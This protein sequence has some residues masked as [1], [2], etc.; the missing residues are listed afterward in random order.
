M[1][2]ITEIKYNLACGKDYREGYINV[3]NGSMFTSKVD[4]DADLNE[5]S[6]SREEAD[7]IL[8]SH[9]VMYLT[10]QNAITLF[11]RW[12][13]GL[14]KGGQLILEMQD[15]KKLAKTILESKEASEINN[16]VVQFY[17]AGATRGHVWTWCEETLT[18]LLKYSGFTNI[19]R[20]EGGL[21]NRLDRDF[22][23]IATK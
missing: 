5:F 19:E 16:Q 6:I 17:G 9:F 15:L 11:E 20:F 10:P 7:T 14:K 13:F 1:E 22:T 21:K 23:L 8:V 18:P 4:I 12:N 2:K 3:D